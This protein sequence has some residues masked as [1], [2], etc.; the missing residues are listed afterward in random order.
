MFFFEAT[1][2]H[3]AV[4]FILFVPRSIAATHYTNDPHLKLDQ[5]KCNTA[6]CIKIFSR[7]L[8]KGFT[9]HLDSVPS[10]KCT[11]SKYLF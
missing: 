10:E 11:L 1:D 8:Q 3:R 6:V 7:P 5:T 4:V 9:T 2:F